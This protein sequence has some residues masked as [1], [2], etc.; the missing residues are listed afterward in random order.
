MIGEQRPMWDRITFGAID[1]GLSSVDLQ[2]LMVRASTCSVRGVYVGQGDYNVAQAASEKV[3]STEIGIM[4]GSP[5]GGLTSQTMV[6]GLC[7]AQKVGCTSVATTLPVIQALAEDVKLMQVYL[8]E[9]AVSGPLSMV[10]ADLAVGNMTFTAAIQ[11]V[12]LCLE[13]G[14]TRFCLGTGS[15]LDRT[16][17]EHVAFITRKLKELGLKENGYTLEAAYAGSSWEDITRYLAAGAHFV[18]VCGYE[19]IMELSSGF[20]VSQGGRRC[21]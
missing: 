14:I 10:I 21:I 13:A 11:V 20:E 8:A 2:A 18:R 12:R 7:W 17:V 5:F 19:S 9:M 15:K 4:L 1:S 6:D 16:E 3:A